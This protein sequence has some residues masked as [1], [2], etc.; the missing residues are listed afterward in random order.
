M[1]F[2]YQIFRKEKTGITFLHI[3]F[4]KKGFV[5]RNGLTIAFLTMFLFSIVGQALTGYNEHNDELKKDK[6]PPISFSHY[7]ASGHFIEATFENW[8]SE[9]LQMAL[10]VLLTRGLRQKGSSES[11]KLEGM[12]EVDRQ[13][14]PKKK[15]APWPVHK[16][17]F[18][19]TL[20]KN[21]LSLILILLYVVSFVFHVYGS[22][23]DNN[24]EQV[25]MGLP[26][27]TV[28]KFLEGPRIWFESFQNWQSE[29]L[30]IAAIIVLSIY[31]RQQGSSQSKPVDAP[32]SQTGE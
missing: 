17:G 13:P 3:L 23:I 9:F 7:L 22:W 21:S 28:I 29:F 24:E 32:H 15:D 20:Y 10:F 19:L 1:L 2:N 4:M 25:R 31:F 16:G 6:Y 14:D 18:I 8:E 30:S 27:E 11:K 26:Q 5:F 12:E